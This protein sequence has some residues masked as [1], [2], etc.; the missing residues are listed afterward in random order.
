MRANLQQ[1]TLQRRSHPHIVDPIMFG[2]MPRLSLLRS[3]GLLTTICHSSGHRASLY[4]VLPS[5]TPESVVYIFFCC[6]LAFFSSPTTLPPPPP[7]PCIFPSPWIFPSFASHIPSWLGPARESIPWLLLEILLRSSW[8]SALSLHLA[9][10]M[11]YH[12][13][14]PSVL[15][16]APST[17]AGDFVIEIS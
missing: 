16:A 9:L 14:A 3:R 13:L 15:V 17:E 6:C 2:L 10:L 8:S 1:H 5:F 11:V 7:S 12:F 4:L